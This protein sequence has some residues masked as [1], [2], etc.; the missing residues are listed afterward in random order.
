MSSLNTGERGGVSSRL[1]RRE[2]RDLGSIQTIIF[3][4]FFSMLLLVGGIGWLSY[5]NTIA[6]AKAVLWVD[7]THDEIEM[8]NELELDVR[9]AESSLRSYMLTND[10]A[11]RDEYH[12]Q[13]FDD[14][15]Y[16]L[17]AVR[18]LSAGSHD[19]LKRLDRIE[20]LLRKRVSHFEETRKLHESN[21]ADTARESDQLRF[22]AIET[23]QLVSLFD[24]FSTHEN[25]LMDERIAQ[26]EYDARLVTETII[27]GGALAFACV[28]VALYLIF[29]ALRSRSRIEEKLRVSLDEKESLLKEIHHRV[30]NN[31]QVISSLLSLESAKIKNT[32]AAVVFKECRDRIHLMSRLH[33]QLYS[34]GQFAFVDF[35][36]HLREMAELLVQSHM[37]A[38]CNV[39]LE[40]RAGSMVVDLDVAITLGLI[41][42]EVILNSLKHAFKGRQTGTLVVELRDGPV[43]EIVVCDNGN[44]LPDGFDPKKRGG[45]GLDLIFGLSRQI[46]GEAIIGKGPEGGTRITI[47]FPALIANLKPD[48]SDPKP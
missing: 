35:G 20:P 18:R 39:T 48:N 40:V 7:Q 15:E 3:A 38:G 22:G 12:R 9:E 26:R 10:P 32:E 29:R 33:Q 31:L 47:R 14:M 36:E 25:S 19:L 27:A 30:K 2:S 28:G 17:S 41:A 6:M 21:S 1:F 37:P 16:H 42:N 13:A 43:R 44:G 34:K 5:R 24:E 4:G 46:N 11:W 8:L 45:F 23:K